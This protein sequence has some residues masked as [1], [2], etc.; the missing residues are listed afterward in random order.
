MSTAHIDWH[1]KP[2]LGLQVCAVLDDSSR[3]I[4]TGREF[5]HCN[6]ENTLPVVDE[7]E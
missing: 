4:T 3:M 6:M 2:H 5:V 1:E 7:L